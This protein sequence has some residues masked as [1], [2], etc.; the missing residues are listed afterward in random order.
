M[1]SIVRVYSYSSTRAH[2]RSISYE[3]ICTSPSA[4][5]KATTKCV[6]HN[7]HESSQRLWTPISKSCDSFLFTF[8]PDVRR[9]HRRRSAPM[10]LPSHHT[11][12][13]TRAHANT[14]SVP[15]CRRWSASWTEWERKNECERPQTKQA[16]NKRTQHQSESAQLNQS[17]I[18]SGWERLWLACWQLSEGAPL[19][20]TLTSNRVEQLLS[21]YALTLRHYIGPPTHAL[22]CILAYVTSIGT[23]AKCLLGLLSPFYVCQFAYE[24]QRGREIKS[25]ANWQSQRLGDNGNA[26]FST[27]ASEAI[28]MF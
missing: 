22:H 11:H 1:S 28:C 10:P 4:V 26:F 19:I 18:D 2:A 6:W 9:R 16:S 14:H 17:A 7:N 24:T 25:A 8:A 20:C 21:T 13:H 23:F 5:A 12:I 3:C 15:H 27:L